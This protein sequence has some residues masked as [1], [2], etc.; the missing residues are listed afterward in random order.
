MFLLNTGSDKPYSPQQA[1]LLVRKLAS[2]PSI[3][4]NE[5]LLTETYK[6]SPS[7]GEATL[8]ALEQAELISIVSGPGG[9]PSAI[10]PGKPVYA[11]AFRHLC[12]DKV[13]SARLD[14]KTL[15]ELT[16]G[17]V[18][19][20]TKAEQELSVLG[21][22]PGKPA[23]IDFRVRY[24]LRKVLAGQDKVEDY[25]RQSKVLKKILSEEF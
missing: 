15:D 1:W 6:S 19:G 7:G 24:L 18:E 16:K 9:R 12:Q 17:E 5:L 23:E 21:G 20:I 25:E 2:K 11:A 10:K 13:L 3:R 8:Q 22:L 14:L 4:Y